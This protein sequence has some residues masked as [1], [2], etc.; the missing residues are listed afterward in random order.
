MLVSL[1]LVL[2]TEDLMLVHLQ[3]LRDLKNVMVAIA[4]VVNALNKL[5]TFSVAVLATEDLALL[6]K[7]PHAHL[8]K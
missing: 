5:M 2:L 3:M 7:N 8:A 6:A 4:A 1:K